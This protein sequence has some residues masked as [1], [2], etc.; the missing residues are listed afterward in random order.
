MHSVMAW[1]LAH[2][3]LD[4]K[5]NV[6]AFIDGVFLTNKPIAKLIVENGRCT[7]VECVDGASYRADK[8]VLLTIHSIWS[9]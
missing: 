1:F 6:P 3:K 5:V 9:K 7:G 2:S 4:V 8:A